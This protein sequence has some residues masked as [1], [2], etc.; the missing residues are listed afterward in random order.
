MK[1]IIAFFTK[2]SKI[3]NILVY[4]YRGLVVANAAFVA[5]FAALKVEK[6][7]DDAYAK[8]EDIPEYLEA[9]AKAVKK[10]LEWMGVDTRD[11]ELTASRD[12]SLTT[13]QPAETRPLR[14]ITEA[15]KD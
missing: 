3:R 13:G 2:G 11:I 8:L 1:K 6:P 4:L 5:G 12:V 15:L 10:I 14:G 9:A 7:E